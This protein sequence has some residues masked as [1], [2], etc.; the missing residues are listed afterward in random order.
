MRNRDYKQFAPGCIVHLYNRGNN[1]ENIFYDEQDY[2]AFIFR[3]GLGLGFESKEL[4]DHPMAS[5]PYSRIRIT[6]SK[7]GCFKLHAFCLMK[8]H[9]H[10]LIEQCSDVPISKLISKICTS[11][12]MYINKKHKRVGHVFQD[13]FKAVLIEDEPQLMWASAYIH[14]NPVKNGLVGHPS[15]YRWSSYNDYVSERNLPITCTDMLELFKND[16]EKETIS[17]TLNQDEVSR[18]VLDITL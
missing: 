18:T 10:F 13:K 7:K 8:N 14:T 16:F 1:R 4:I 15:Q 2:K 3:I 12:A 9:F 17:I 5:L 11:Y 6:N